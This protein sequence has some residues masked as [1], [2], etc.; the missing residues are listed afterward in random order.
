MKKVIALTVFL[1]AT[2]LLATFTIQFMTNYYH[3]ESYMNEC[4]F[5]AVRYLPKDYSVSKIDL[6]CYTLYLKD[7]P[8][9]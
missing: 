9:K 1:I 3:K 7:Y 5:Y 8:S 6:W 2:Y 4:R